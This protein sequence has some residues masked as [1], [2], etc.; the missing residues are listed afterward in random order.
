MLIVVSPAKSLDYESPLP[1]RKFTEPMF[2]DRSEELIAIMRT[3]TTRQIE[4]LMSISPTLAQLNHDRYHDWQLPFTPKTARPAL[5]AFNGDVYDGMKA[6]STFSTAD[7]THAQK[8]FRILSGLYGVLRPLDLMMP[9]RLEMGTRLKNDRGSDLYAYWG[10]V[11][12]DALRTDL[13]ASP[14]QK[15]L[16][17]LASTEYFSSVRPAKLGAPV[18]SP[19]FLD[20]SRDGSYKIV[21]FFAKKARGVMSAWLIRERIS[22]VKAI[23]DFVG[24]GYRF[25]SARSS[26]SRPAFI[27]S[28]KI[29]AT[30]VQTIQ[31]QPTPNTDK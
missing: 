30:E 17:N 20:E 16:I 9:Y 14:G 11:I 19:V 27:R 31:T 24:S 29:A 1:T 2:L 25:D 13:L 23:Q 4:T 3:R 21:S 8:T 7:F 12:T 10:D 6:R 26:E 22:K 28:A 5:L 18:V 15:V